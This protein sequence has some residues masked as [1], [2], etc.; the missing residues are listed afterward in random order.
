MVGTGFERVIDQ[1]GMARPLGIVPSEMHHECSQCHQMKGYNDFAEEQVA[2]PALTRAC[3]ACSSSAPRQLEQ[4]AQED[5]RAR[6]EQLKREQ[7]CRAMC[8]CSPSTCCLSSP[9]TPQTP[10]STGGG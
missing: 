4:P 2:L 6:Q 1:F 3:I 10:C 8:S 7:A 9:L 5:D